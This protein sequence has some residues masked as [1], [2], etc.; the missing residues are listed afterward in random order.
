M[1]Q[2]G[3]PEFS[4]SLEFLAFQEIATQCDGYVYV[5]DKQ[6]CYVFVNE[7]ICQLFQLPKEQILGKDDSHFFDL[8][9]LD[10]L[11]EHDQTVLLKGET[12]E[13]DEHNLILSSSEKR[14]YKTKKFPVRN[15]EG[16]IIG[17]AGIST[18]IT[19]QKRLEKEL[20]SQYHLM[21]AILNNVDAYVYVKSH[22]RRFLYVND[23]TAQL[24]GKSVE[25]I[26]G[27]FDYEVIPDNADELWEMDKKV[28]LSHSK[29]TGEETFVGTDGI[30]RHYWSVKVPFT[31]DDAAI[32]GFSSDIT[33][34]Y[35]LKER[36]K[37]QANSDALTQAASRRFFF[38][39]AEQEFK[40][41]KR[42]DSPMS[43][44]ML[45]VDYFKTVND[46]Y[47]HQVGDKVLQAMVAFLKEQI[48][49]V[50][51]IGRLGGEEF[52]LLLPNTSERDAVDLA[53][54]L[55]QTIADNSCVM[56]DNKEFVRITVSLGVSTSLPEDNDFDAVLNRADKA[57]YI[58]KKQ[59]RNQVS[60][61]E[62]ADN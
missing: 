47:G 40:K 59:G 11:L 51:I 8:S 5:K 18:D 62:T 42:Y 61:I 48:R 25:E 33:E 55:R 6:G 12:V 16:E 28:L 39:M 15:L 14:V 34:L 43:V 20:Q 44:I 49:D 31:H 29:H 35:Q 57:L 45:D 32:I 13:V 52:A 1:A 60:L 24:F 26:V 3:T 21:D 41:I 30:T 17:L 22:D 58:S 10:K 54:R 38:E 53:E 9:K 46:R 4:Q 50:D 56:T 37:E 36:L 27:S 23:Q 2:A 7:K 19:E